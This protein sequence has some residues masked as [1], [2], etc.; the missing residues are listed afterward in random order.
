[1]RA[2]GDSSPG[3]FDERTLASNEFYPLEDGGIEWVFYF[4]RSQVP[5]WE[6][7]TIARAERD[8]FLRLA[9]TFG[10]VDPESHEYRSV[11][12]VHLWHMD[13]LPSKVSWRKVLVHVFTHEP[14]HHAIGRAL[15]E[16]GERGDQEWII[17]NLGDGRW[18]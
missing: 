8:H 10:S 2:Q 13:R 1:M 3:T 18:W 12:A 17:R 4:R 15:A 5:P 16:V 14:L 7:D 6:L 11:T 9:V